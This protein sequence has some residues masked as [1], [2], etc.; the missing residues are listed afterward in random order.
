MGS[1]VLA[2]TFGNMAALMA[3]IGKKE[4]QFNELFDKI[5]GLM[6]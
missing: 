1:I 6:R 3:S 4:A 2:F 5:T